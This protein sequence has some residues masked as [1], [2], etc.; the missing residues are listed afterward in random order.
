MK[1]DEWTITDADPVWDFHVEVLPD[2]MSGRPED[3]G[4]DYDAELMLRLADQDDMLTAEDGEKAADWA[5]RAVAA[6]E[7]DDWR[8]AILTVT[9]VHKGTGAVFVD[10]TDT[11]GGVDYGW[12]PGPTAE[13]KGVWTSDREYVRLT[14]VDDMIDNVRGL[15]YEALQKAQES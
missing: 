9:P 2:P 13:D 11:L 14:W 7:N 5:R 1:L 3:N 8:F 12:L 6:W 10:Q 15:A 4:D